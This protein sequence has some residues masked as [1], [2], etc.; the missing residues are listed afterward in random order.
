M[1]FSLVL[2]L[3]AWYFVRSARRA[4][5]LGDLRLRRLSVAALVGLV[6]IAAAGIFLS[7]QLSKPIWILIGLAIALDSITSG[8][9]KQSPLRAPP[10]VQPPPRKR[11]TDGADD[12]SV[13]PRVDELLRLEAGL[14]RSPASRRTAPRRGSGLRR[15]SE[16]RRAWTLSELDELMARPGSQGSK[17][18]HE[19]R[20]SFLA[21]VR[22]HADADGRLPPRFDGVVREHFADL[23][24]RD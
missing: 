19:R 6:G 13:S 22:R 24:D 7:N 20:R 23:S 9:S 18:A 3:T 14:R 21:L 15:G 5:G 12:K 8:A 16:R 1:W 2:V 10:I 4:S 17:A 11:P